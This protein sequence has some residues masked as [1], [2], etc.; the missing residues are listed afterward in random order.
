[1]SMT[2][3]DDS[4][5]WMDDAPLAGRQGSGTPTTPPTTPTAPTAP[6]AT[7]T[8]PTT[9]ITTAIVGNPSSKLRPSSLE[10]PSKG[11]GGVVVDAFIADAPVAL[12]AR[13]TESDARRHDQ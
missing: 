1:M 11:G 8:A 13:E 6:I 7:P 3:K 5:S 9:P 12:D 2:L 4:E 10:N